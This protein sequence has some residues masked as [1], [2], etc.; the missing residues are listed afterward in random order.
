MVDLHSHIL[1][2]LD[3][4]AADLD[5]SIQMAREAAG[6]GVHTIVAT[7]HVNERYRYDLAEIER[8]TDELQGELERRGIPL[9]VLSG[10]E[11][12]LPMLD[13]LSDRELRS[14]CL[15]FGP[16]ILIESPYGTAEAGIEERVLSLVRRGL[17]PVL[18]HPERC[19]LFQHEPDRVNSLV[20]LGVV[21]S[22]NAGSLVGYF[23]GTVRQFA[24]RLISEGLVHDVA[25][26]AHDHIV[27]APRLTVGFE[28]AD[29]D[30]PGILAQRHWY[31]VAAPA[32]I[33][34]GEPLPPRPAPPRPRRSGLAGRLRRRR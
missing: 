30:L 11:V 20:A 7:P 10:A 17:Q 5:A 6:D 12:A 31:T 18:A 29:A 25:S 27:R 1:P 33:V 28:F 15:G 32:A 26:D 8:L 4:G 2:G 24:L 21:C 13:G 3:D 22:V 23:G 9:A 14:L 19:P 16:S 34:A